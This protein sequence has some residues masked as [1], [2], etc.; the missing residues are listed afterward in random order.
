MRITL[1]PINPANHSNCTNAGGRKP[2]K[3]CLLDGQTRL[4]PEDI[5]SKGQRSLMDTDMYVRGRDKI[6]FYKV[7]SWPLDFPCGSTCPV[8]CIFGVEQEVSNSMPQP[9]VSIIDG[10]QREG[11]GIGTGQSKMVRSSFSSQARKAA[12]MLVSAWW[13]SLRLDGWRVA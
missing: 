8:P 3:N 7:F 9:L 13:S 12:P 11:A 4:C 10:H 1:S 6:R 2:Q 5:S